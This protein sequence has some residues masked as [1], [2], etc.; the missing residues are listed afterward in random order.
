[1][2]GSGGGIPGAGEPRP[3]PDACRARVVCPG[4]TGSRGLHTRPTSTG[5]ECIQSRGALLPRRVRGPRPGCKRA[6]T[7]P[8]S[9][10]RQG[11]RLGRRRRAAAACGADRRD[12]Y[13]VLSRTEARFRNS[14][15]R[16]VASPASIAA[17][18]SLASSSCTS[19][20]RKRSREAS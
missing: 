8:S 20:R 13:S 6:P 4:H 16:S 1:M 15:A 11:D 14:G 7:G 2:I 9:T 10:R 5:C 17:V 3:E 12:G 18:M 19:S